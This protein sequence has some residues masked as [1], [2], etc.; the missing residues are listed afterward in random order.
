[1][2]KKKNK[3]NKMDGL[4]LSMSKRISKGENINSVLDDVKK[5]RKLTELECEILL[6]RLGEEMAEDLLD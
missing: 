6:E 2:K 1:M 4:F 3:K 5:R